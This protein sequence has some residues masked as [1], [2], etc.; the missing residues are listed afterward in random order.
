VPPA[1]ACAWLSPCAVLHACGCPHAPSVA[2]PCMATCPLTASP[3]G[4]VRAEVPQD[5]LEHN[6]GEP[7][8]RKGHPRH[9]RSPPRA[10][11]PHGP[12]RRSRQQPPKVSPGGG[13][14]GARQ[15]AAGRGAWRAEPGELGPSCAVVLPSRTWRRWCG[16]APGA[17]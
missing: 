15:G 14:E 12:S 6:T 13:T 4:A 2:V 17:W 9:Q 10:P 1:R 11:Q 5:C 3:Q 16:T 8:G 7:G